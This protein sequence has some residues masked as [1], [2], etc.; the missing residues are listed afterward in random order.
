[1]NNDT[2]ALPSEV[3]CCAQHYVVHFIARYDKWLFVWLD[4]PQQLYP[5]FSRHMESLVSIDTRYIIGH[6]I[7]LLK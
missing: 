3:L 4:S 2:N 5:I 6:V 7:K 1:M